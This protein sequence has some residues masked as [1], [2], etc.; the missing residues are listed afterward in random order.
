MKSI[1]MRKNE[2]FTRNAFTTVGRF[3]I[4]LVEKQIINLDDVA[5][6]AY[7]NTKNNDS[8]ENR[9][10]GVHFFIDDYKF[11]SVYKNPE[12]SLGRLS[13]Y[14]FL[15]TPDYSTYSDMNYWKQL[16]SVSHSRWV[17]AYWQEQGQNVIPT[18][19]WS[20][21]KSFDFCFEG[22]ER[23]AIVAIGMIGCKRSKQEFLLGYSEMLKRIEPSHIICFGTPFKEMEGNLIVVDYLPSGKVVS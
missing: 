10:K 2:F 13:Q 6:I 11:E 9:K 23:N 17:G 8:E 12:Y 7:S 4:P 22:V 16:E 14:S 21:P 5:L 19:S 3:E 15:L 1:D 20:T 18:I